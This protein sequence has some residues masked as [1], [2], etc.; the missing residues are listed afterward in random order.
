M[1]TWVRSQ[2]RVLRPYFGAQAASTLLYE[3]ELV[4]KPGEAPTLDRRVVLDEQQMES[5]SPRLYPKLIEEQIDTVF[6]DMRSEFDLVVS[7]RTPQLLRRELVAHHPLSD[8]APSW[9]DVAYERLRD[10]KLTGLFELSI[11]ICLSRDVDLG[12]G[13]PSQKGSWVARETF[14]VGLDRRQSAFRILPLTKA[15]IESLKLPNG[16]FVY[17]DD[18]EDLNVVYAEGE[19][20][21]TAYVAEQ[22]LLNAAAGRSPAVTSLIWS[23]IVCAI[24]SADGSG[25]AEAQEVTSGSPLEAILEYLRPNRAMNLAELK[26][27]IVDPVLLR[28]AVHDSRRLVKDL[29]RI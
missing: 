1:K 26:K 29:E 28:A 21:A 2:P 20:C 14:T 15:I 23:E 19:S 25:I 17:V 13:W 7:L 6:G 22:V 27:L 18:I 3:A 11:S 8:G 12:A 9:I 4:L 16:T 24:L 5:V 10:G